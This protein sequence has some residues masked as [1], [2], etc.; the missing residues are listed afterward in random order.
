MPLNRKKFKTQPV[1][2]EGESDCGTKA[3]ALYFR[4][5]DHI[6]FFLDFSVCTGLHKWCLGP[7]LMVAEFLPARH[8]SWWWP[9]PRALGIPGASIRSLFLVPSSLLLAASPIVASPGGWGVE[10][11]KGA[12]T[13]PHF[14]FTSAHTSVNHIYTPPFSCISVDN[15]TH[16]RIE[17][18]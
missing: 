4:T 8:N 11:K 1:R 18:N 3:E 16:R 9:F 6:F 7:W 2:W 10:G 13:F 17:R 5:F 12:I 14:A 15:F